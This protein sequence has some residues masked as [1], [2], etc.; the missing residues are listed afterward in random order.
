MI[1]IRRYLLTVTTKSPL[2]GTHKDSGPG[3]K[4]TFYRNGQ[5]QAIILARQV[6][7][8]LKEASAALSAGLRRGIG[9]EV[10][11][12]V[13]IEPEELELILPDGHEVELVEIPRRVRSKDGPQEVVMMKAE[14]VPVGTSF[15]CTLVLYPGVQEETIRAILAY[16]ERQG[17]G[18]ARGEGFGRFKFG[19]RECNDD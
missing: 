18:Q 5:G 14:A 4:M 6:K 13:F 10:R 7:G 9:R 17:L 1:E 16:G 19:L 15:A 12:R 11:Q 3:L 8:F 2:L